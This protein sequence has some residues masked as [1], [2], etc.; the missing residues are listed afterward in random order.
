VSCENRPTS[1]RRVAIAKTPPGASGN[2]GGVDARL[3][4]TARR[5]AQPLL[6]NNTAVQRVQ[7][8]AGSPPHRPAVLLPLVSFDKYQSR[9][10]SRPVTALGCCVVDLGVQ[11]FAELANAYVNRRIRRPVTSE[12]DRF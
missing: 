11:L 9:E 8:H 5:L 4:T 7:R 12:K 2:D 3:I 10:S 6:A 1:K